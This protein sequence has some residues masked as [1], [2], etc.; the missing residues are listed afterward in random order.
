[1][2]FFFNITRLAIIL[3]TGISAQFSHAVLPIEDYDASK[4]DQEMTKPT[5]LQDSVDQL[6]NFIAEKNKYYVKGLVHDDIEKFVLKSVI[7]EN[8]TI[9]SDKDLKF[10][11]QNKMHKKLEFKDLAEIADL[12]TQKYQQ[13]GYMLSFAVIPT[14]KVIDGILNIVIIEG[15]IDDVMLVDKTPKEYSKKL[16]AY[17]ELL[18]KTKPMTRV[19]YSQFLTKANLLPGIAVSPNLIPSPYAFGASTL[20]LK[21]QED[22][23]NADISKTNHISERYGHNINTM[24][25]VYNS[26]LYGYEMGVGYARNDFASHKKLEAKNLSYKHFVGDNG[27]SISIDYGKNLA[28][29]FFDSP[30]DQLKFSGYSKQVNFSLNYPLLQTFEKTIALN[31]GIHAKKNDTFVLNILRTN[32]KV[33]VLQF[34]VLYKFNTSLFNK[35]GN[36]VIQADLYKGLSGFGAT[37][38]TAV[39]LSRPAAKVNFTKINVTAARLQQ[40]RDNIYISAL[41]EGQYAFSQLLSMEEYSF[42]GN[43]LGRG[44][45]SSIIGGDH[46]MAGKLE[47]IYDFHI[48]TIAT[49]QIYCAYELGKVWHKRTLLPDE[50]L[51]RS[52]ASAI[53]GIRF[54]VLRHVNMD[55]SVSKPLS[56]LSS[57]GNKKPR[58]FATL[59]AKL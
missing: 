34:G 37:P 42:G 55:V 19:A 50:F 13:A 27:A 21:V 9:F 12:I 51:G 3:Y 47:L 39:N 33:R 52:A 31:M 54:A 11:Y 29:P 46:G 30:L 56:H 57:A 8:N 15:A 53:A 41:L 7:I 16:F 40:L 35:I 45:E 22:Q 38:M 59:G 6:Q 20:I 28:K 49:S 43:K 23:I 1:M 48:K 58:Y 18:L 5:D 26:I 44:Y 36:S 32:D 25:L 4:I 14:Q 10:S 24:H 17:A 2:K